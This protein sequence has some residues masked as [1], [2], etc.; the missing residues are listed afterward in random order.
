M[1]LGQEARRI[2]IEIEYLL[3][4]SLTEET[5]HVF[6]SFPDASQ[7]SDDLSDPKSIFRQNSS[8]LQ[9]RI[10]QVAE[11][12]VQSFE[13]EEQMLAWLSRNDEILTRL[14]VA[15]ALTCG[16]PPRGF[17][18]ASLQYDLCP[19]TGASRGLFLI[20][21]NL[22]IAKPA[23]KQTGRYRQDCLWFLPPV[24]SSSMVFYL[25]IFRPV[26]IQ[27]LTLLRKEVIHQDTYIFCRTTPRI[28]SSYSWTGDEI[29]RMLQ[30]HTKHF[31]I[32]LSVGLIRQLYTALF[33][34]YFPDLCAAGPQED[35]LVDRQGQHRNYTGQRHYGLITNIP[36]SLGIDLTEARKM[37][38]MSQLLHV[39]FGLRIADERLR[40][41]LER[42]HFLPCSK[43]EA[44]A[45]DTARVL[46]VSQYGISSGGVGPRAAIKART[47]LKDCPYF[48]V[49]GPTFTVI[50]CIFTI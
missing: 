28:G 44:H 40:L 42:I 50:H 22:A 33:R 35:A 20:D 49:V 29:S 27:V 12:V 23:A 30:H 8:L 37:G 26:V 17:Q 36:R 31:K 39:I 7:L 15:V 45:L 21:G 34:Q 46:V 14:L 25:G 10:T 4:Q 18:F 43:H 19:Q 32:A 47:L 38:A 13:N 24:L 3:S 2:V 9:P 11:A 5:S 48:H 16:V 1:D 41:D 6:A